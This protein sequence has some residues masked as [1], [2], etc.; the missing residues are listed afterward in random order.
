VRGV[1]ISSHRYEI[2]LTDKKSGMQIT[3]NL[4]NDHTK[5]IVKADGYQGYFKS[6]DVAIKEAFTH[7]QAKLG[8]K[9]EQ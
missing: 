2:T 7:M 4:S 6:L 3:V 1:I 9:G 8:E 5:W